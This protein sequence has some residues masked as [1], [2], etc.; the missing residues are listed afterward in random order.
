LTLRT[1]LWER[2]LGLCLALCFLCLPGVSAQT[3]A[4][5]EASQSAPLTNPVSP[6]GPTT[7]QVKSHY[8]I[9]IDA[10][11]GKVLWSRNPDAE[12]EIAST[13]KMMTAILLLEH[14]A[15]GHENDIVTAPNGLQGIPESSLHLSPGETISLHDLLYAMMLRSANDT[16]VAGACYMSGSVPAFVQ[17]MNEKAQAIGCT[18]THFVTPNGLYAPGHHSTAA[19]LA[20]IAAY[21]VNNL[22]EFNAIVHT[23]KYKVT[24]SMH[25]ND[26]WVKNTA[27][28]FLKDFPGADGI[29]T[30]YIQAAGHCFVGSATRSDPDG[31]PWR[32]IAVALDSNSC[33]E[34]VMSLLNYG[35]AN[36][37]PTLAV[38][39]DVPLGTVD[40]S[41]AA[42]P[43][44]VRAGADVEAVVSK[45]HPIP[46]FQ[47][48]VKPLPLLP[49]A[50]IAAGTKLGTFVVLL[51]GKPQAVGDAVA[52]QG[53]DLKP[54]MAF[55][56]TTKSFGHGAL[57]WVSALFGLICFAALVRGIYYHEAVKSAAAKRRRIQ[58]AR[59]GKP[60]V[61]RRGAGGTAA[62]SPRRRR[63]RLPSDV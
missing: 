55:A 48:R 53:V 15:Q 24:R 5:S 57:R 58:Q 8:A 25:V 27:M 26:V 60:G 36:Y 21:A 54:A 7:P 43:V 23:Q 11:T 47:T 3:P 14:A 61:R 49:S 42:T 17:Q 29:K 6:S 59:A 12:R 18:H 30:G 50:P 51:H 37:R 9:L 56:K 38:P 10:V 28:T 4:D 32:L 16:A 1:N 35:F 40:V 22:P 52:A 41:T 13:T 63:D 46:A 39:K 45:W 33:R 19:D 44:P 2:L 34:D 62:K 31:R 20:K